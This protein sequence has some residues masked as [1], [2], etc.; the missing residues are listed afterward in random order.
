MNTKQLQYFLT[1]INK[2]SIAGAAREL[3]IAQPAISQQISKLEHELQAQL[4]VR[5][6]RG[7]KLTQSGEKFLEYAKSIIRQIESAKTDIKNTEE[8]PSGIVSIGMSQSICNVLSVPLLA[9]VKRRYPRIQLTINTGLSYT[10]HDWLRSGKI[11]LAISYLDGS[12]MSTIHRELLITE[13]IYLAVSNTPKDPSQKNIIAR[14]TI[15]FSA[16]SELEVMVTGRKDA[17]GYLLHKYELETGININKESSIDQLMSALRS[18]TNG[19]SILL[20][21]SSATFHL[22]ELKQIKCIEIVEPKVTREVFLMTS[23]DRPQANALMK[24]MQLVK[25]VTQ[26]AHE[27]SRWRGKLASFK[28]LS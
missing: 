6:F 20:V 22:E 3:D 4:F 15:P 11:D 7:V 17:L 2:G 28:N 19:D 13:N 10:M 21:P 12:D 25:Q 5:D 1:T 26:K 14:E 27:E 18:V 16:L 8:N 23:I 24:V 9:A